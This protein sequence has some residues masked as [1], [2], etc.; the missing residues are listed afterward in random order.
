MSVSAKKNIAVYRALLDSNGEKDFLKPFTDF[1][2]FYIYNDSIASYDIQTLCCGVKLEFGIDIPELPMKKIVGRLITQNILSPCQYSKYFVKDRSLI[3]DAYDKF[4][5]TYNQMLD[6]YDKITYACQEYLKNEFQTDIRY[7]ELSNKFNKFILKRIDSIKFTASDYDG[8][9]D[10]IDGDMFYYQLGKFIDKKCKKNHFEEVIKRLMV[11]ELLSSSIKVQQVYKTEQ[12]AKTKIVL[13]TPI[14]L[15][16]LGLSEYGMEMIYRNMVETARKI[17][18]QICVFEHSVEEINQILD[19]AKNRINRSDYN[20]TLASDVLSYYVKK[21]KSV[22]D[23]SFDI[24]MLKNNLKNYE[25]EILSVDINDKNIKYNES[26]DSLKNKIGTTYKNINEYTKN[27]TS[28]EYDAKSINNIF[29]IRKGALPQ[30]VF[31]CK[32]VFVTSNTALANVAHRYYKE[33]HNRKSF[34]TVVTDVYF[35]TLLWLNDTIILEEISWKF[36]IS[37]VYAAFQ[38]S[39]NFWSLYLSKIDDLENRGDLS[40]EDA[41]VLRANCLIPDEVM[42]MTDG[43]IRKISDNLPMDVYKRIVEREREKGFVE[44]Q[45]EAESKIKDIKRTQADDVVRLQED[46]LNKVK[47]ARN[48]TLKRDKKKTRIRRWLMVEFIVIILIILASICWNLYNAN[49][50][51]CIANIALL[52]PQIILLCNIVFRRKIK[53][54]KREEKGLY[55]S[56]MEVIKIDKIIIFYDKIIRYSIK[57]LRN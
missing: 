42:E 21:G 56:L 31:S 24:F 10:E 36:L 11:G 48:N 20:P 38:P 17:G 13:D 7:D 26:I 52:L 18:A 12:F 6:D 16:L 33:K 9:E 8:G 46:Y 27:D 5:T 50:E 28:V 45:R 29:L 4:R 53:M 39:H 37:Q 55:V 2:K 25:I 57:R 47:R 49:F 34:P 32:A 3:K 15:K 19:G 54:A 41:L 30:D 23:I 35:G 44:A 43:D 14:V 22:E 51:F 40:D 1:T